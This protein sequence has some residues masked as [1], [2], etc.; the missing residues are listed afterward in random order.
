MFYSLKYM[1]QFDKLHDSVCEGNSWIYRKFGKRFNTFFYVFHVFNV[2]VF[3]SERLINL[4][5]A[6]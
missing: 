6:P 4:W 1:P 5:F 2:H 3:L